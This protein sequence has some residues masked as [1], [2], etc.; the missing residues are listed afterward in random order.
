MKEEERFCR[1]PFALHS[2]AAS[3]SPTSYA[4]SWGGRQSEQVAHVHGPEV[5]LGRKGNEPS[6]GRLWFFESCSA[7]DHK[8]SRLRRRM[9]FS[10]LKKNNPFPVV[11]PLWNRLADK[12]L[13]KT[14]MYQL[15]SV[16]VEI[17]GEI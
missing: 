16:C 11:L 1:P 14:N 2:C 12:L 10:S 5:A 4:M 8:A 9:I 13:L 17:E 15:N 3:Y 7:A 6:L